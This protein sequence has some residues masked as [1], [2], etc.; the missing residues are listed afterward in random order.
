MIID[1]HT[2]LICAREDLRE[3]V[4]C[5]LVS[6]GMDPKIWE[7]SEEEYCEG[8]R[9]A[10]RAIVFGLRARKTGWEASNA[11]V[12]DFVRRHAEKYVY[13]AAIDPAEPDCAEQLRN[14]V[15]VHH[16]KGVKLGAIYQGVHPLDE[17][18]MPIY[19]FCEKNG[20]PIISHSAATFSSGVPLD[21]ARPAHM[22]EVACRF[23]GLRLV[24]AHLGHPWEGE[25]LA[26]IRK[27]ECLYADLSALFYRPWQFYNSMMLAVE[28]GCTNKLLFGS[29]FPA[30][31]T[32]ASVAGI[33]GVNRIVQG[34][35]LPK[36]PVEIVESILE[37]DALSALGI[38][39]A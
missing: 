31:T 16:A 34:T 1:M 5:D 20:L 38:G 18:Y 22:D 19:A 29:D 10:D 4:Y 2:H 26:A 25:A 39:R 12:A 14:E 6:S 8:T 17:R 15:S 36:V 23:P 33:R 21:Y 32:E 9:A 7:Y 3:Q 37:R 35:T 28:Y 11:R 27:Q 30:T 24:I 13:F